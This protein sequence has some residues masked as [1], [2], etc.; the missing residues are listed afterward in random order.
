LCERERKIVELSL[1]ILL[2]KYILTRNIDKRERRQTKTR[3]KW[4]GA[5]STK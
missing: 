2:L 1:P 4:R 5:E 3:R